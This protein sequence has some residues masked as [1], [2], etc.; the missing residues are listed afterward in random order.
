MS[1]TGALHIGATGISV[2]QAAL[3]VVGNNLSNSATEGYS[4]QRAIMA[5]GPGV[6]I[7]AG[8]FVGSGVRLQSIVRV[9]DEA[10]NARVRTAT[11]DQ[12]AAL[13][14]QNI[15]SQ[16]ESI[17]GELSD[18]GLSTR[19][20]TFLNQW[21]ELAS[22]PNDTGVK[23][24]VIAQGQSLSEHLQQM[25]TE[26]ANLRKQVD[27]SLASGVEVA[28]GLLT[29]VADL[30]RRIALEESGQGGANSLRD[31]RDRVLDELA[32]YVNITTHE[33]PSGQIDVF[34]DSTPIVLGTESRGLELE[35]V[36][37]D[38]ELITKLRV[39]ADGTQ[40]TPSGGQLGQLLVTRNNDINPAIAEVDQFAST[41]IFELNKLHSSGQ[42]SSA[43]TSLTGA[44]LNLDPTAALNDQVANDLP[45]EIV[46]GSFQIHVTQKTTGADVATQIDVDLDGLGADTTLNDLAAAIDAVANISAS[47][48]PDGTLSITSDSSDYT[49][50]FSDDSSGAL[51]SLGLNTFFTGRD[52]ASIDVNE[53]LVDD[54]GYLAVGSDHVAGSNGTALAIAGVADQSLDSLNGLS[55]NQAWKKHVEELAVQT[56]TAN[57]NVEAST[58]I[59]ESLTN[60][61]ASV[62][63]V[64]VD[65]ETINLLQFQ[66]AFQ[67]S[68]RFISV[69]D[70]LMQTLLGLV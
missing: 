29:Q 43:F 28:N 68:A 53:I 32:E 50:S 2:N 26:L 65:E 70:E 34:V 17:E 37:E 3:E 62:S 13:A 1:L 27:S 45:F 33:Q 47:V 20:S 9:V 25:R 46:N 54:P 35:T 61:K 23:S 19:L 69:V 60:Q 52:A 63:G 36:T 55:L 42:G 51:A 66:R 44:S 48:N 67:G 10:L 58:I 38:G 5:A 7:S 16:V 64:S 4:R 11:S 31:E 6:E 59:V 57:Q 24:L 14:R 15:L 21:S 56:A 8:T 12:Q 22:N 41:L 30:N 18:Q 49:F 39:Q 40:L